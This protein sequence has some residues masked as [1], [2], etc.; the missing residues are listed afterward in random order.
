MIYKKLQH[1]KV[2]LLPTDR[3]SEFAAIAHK[4]RLLKT[5]AAG[6]A[7]AFSG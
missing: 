4:T 3:I 2:D 5:S 1:F 6:T 7:I